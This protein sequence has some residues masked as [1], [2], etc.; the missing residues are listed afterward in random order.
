M[1]WL[2]KLIVVDNLGCPKYK[3]NSTEFV[4]DLKKKITLKLKE[5]VG[6]F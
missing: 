1:S 2:N 5:Y 3:R 6:I 4:V